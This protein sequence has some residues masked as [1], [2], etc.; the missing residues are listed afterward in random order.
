MDHSMH[1]HNMVSTATPSASM[2]MG[3]SACKIS[4]LWNWCADLLDYR[5]T[6]LIPLKNQVYGRVVLH[7]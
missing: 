2:D 1:A 7:L 5:R 4:M 6:D 3:G